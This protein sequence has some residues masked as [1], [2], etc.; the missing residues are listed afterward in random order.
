MPH[1]ARIRTTLAKA[2]ALRQ[3]AADEGY[4]DT[5]YFR[6][7]RLGADVEA[8]LRRA[9][10]IEDSA[11][12]PFHAVPAFEFS[13]WDCQRA[14]RQ[15]QRQEMYA[16]ANPRMRAALDEIQRFEQTGRWKSGRRTL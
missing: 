8:L 16:A 5:R 13:V 9:R 12:I 15:R 11:L 1:T 14:F 7:S 2:E 4:I 6:G 10:E 3:Q